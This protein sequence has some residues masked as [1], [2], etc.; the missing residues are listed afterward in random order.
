ML[1]NFRSYFTILI[2]MQAFYLSCS[3]LCLVNLLLAETELTLM[4]TV[5]AGMKKC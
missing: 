1:D 2:Y 4:L 3:G 5:I